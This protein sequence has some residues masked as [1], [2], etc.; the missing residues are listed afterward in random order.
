MKYAQRKKR[1]TSPQIHKKNKAKAHPDSTALYDTK[2][3]LP[4]DNISPPQLTNT[5]KEEKNF[6]VRL[7]LLITMENMAPPIVNPNKMLKLL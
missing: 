2:E 7:N 4:H 1:K 3:I 6:L 5:T